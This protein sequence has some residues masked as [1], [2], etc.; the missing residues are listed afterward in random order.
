MSATEKG[1]TPVV[2]WRASEM[3]VMPVEAGSNS[4]GSQPLTS[5]KTVSRAN[6]S[7]ERSAPK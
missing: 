5:E 6:A 3:A 2:C 4:G 7:G 1:L